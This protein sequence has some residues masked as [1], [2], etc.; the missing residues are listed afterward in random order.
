MLRIYLLQQ[1]YGLSAPAMEEALY[2]ISSMRQFARL[3][4]T[5]PIPD[6][7]TLL[8]FRHLLE[9]HGLCA[10]LFEVVNGYLQEKGL[11]MRHGTIVD[12]TIIAAPSSTKNRS[13]PT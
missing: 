6:E 3:S 1:W 12:A 13:G 8:H 4:L 9:Q 10:R 5:Q 11:L 7:T 2:E